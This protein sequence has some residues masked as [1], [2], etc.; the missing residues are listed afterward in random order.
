MPI[1]YIAFTE[2]IKKGLVGK[3]YLFYG[4]EDYLIR[5]ALERVKNALIPAELEMLNESRLVDPTVSTFI[6]TVETY[7][8]FCDRR[9]IIVE[10]WQLF[11]N[12]GKENKDEAERLAEYIKN[13][14][15]YACVV[16]VL[17]NKPDG[18]RRLTKALEA[19]AQSVE[20]GKP[21]ENTLARW[22]TR[23]AKAS[24]ISI[25][26]KNARFLAFYSGADLTQLAQEIDKLCVY[27]A[28]SGVVEEEDI[29]ATASQSVSGSIFDLTDALLIGN[30]SG[31]YKVID[32]LKS[33]G[34]SAIG[35][36]S[37]L[38]SQFRKMRLINQV[39]ANSTQAQ[40]ASAVG[41]TGWAFEK[42]AERA[43]KVSAGKLDRA[44]QLITNTDIAIREGDI[45]QEYAI[46]KILLGIA[47]IMHGE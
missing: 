35:L 12:E 45:A 19:A 7:P 26:D 10:Q 47:N 25:S 5:Q 34:E 38:S 27:C 11:S 3:A 6:E 37:F 33:D 2:Q 31:A 40:T 13:I 21:D 28:N 15:E 22:I 23:Q 16:I 4:T 8:A 29:R 41:L 30:T 32:N 14:P 43:K 42:T 17:H 1:D 24:G 36:L 20:F 44:I 9:L 18:K 46:D 39:G